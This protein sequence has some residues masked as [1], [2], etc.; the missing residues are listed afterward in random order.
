VRKQHLAAGTSGPLF[1]PQ[2]KKKDHRGGRPSAV[3]EPE[4]VLWERSLTYPRGCRRRPVAFPY[5]LVA[6]A[7]AAQLAVRV[8][9]GRM[10]RSRVRHF[11]VL[12]LVQLPGRA[13]DVPGRGPGEEAAPARCHLRTAASRLDRSGASARRTF[14]L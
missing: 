5:I 9:G 14:M 6:G 12:G 4:Q 7:Y 3:T 10:H 2:G 13:A 11:R 1:R 8:R